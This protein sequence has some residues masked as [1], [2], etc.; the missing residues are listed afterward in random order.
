MLD[1]TLSTNFLLVELGNNKRVRKK[2][3]IKRKIGVIV[4]I[5]DFICRLQESEVGNE[6][7]T[8]P[9]TNNK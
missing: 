7:S 6:H 5:I 3:C 1:L 2:L 9:A 8:R 4:N